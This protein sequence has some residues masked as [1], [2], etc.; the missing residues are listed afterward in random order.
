MSIKTEF[1][2]ILESTAKKGNDIRNQA[3]RV[4]RDPAYTVDGK[5]ERIERLKG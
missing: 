3:L 4:G 5:I 1:I 2:S